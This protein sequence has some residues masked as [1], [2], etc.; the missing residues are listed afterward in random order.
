M[1][2][3]HSLYGALFLYFGSQHW[4]PGDTP[5]EITVGAMLTQ[6]VAWT[7]VEKAIIN[8][9]AADLLDL[10]KMSQSN[11]ENLKELIKPVGFYNQ[12]GTRLIDFA[13]YVCQKYGSIETM[14]DKPT[15]KVREELLGIKGIGPETADSILL[16]AGSHLTF[17]IDAYTKRLAR[18]LAIPQ[19][20]DYHALKNIFETNLPKDVQ[21][22][23]EYHALIVRLGK[24]FCKTKPD[25]ANCPVI[26]H[27]R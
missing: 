27:K 15:L 13:K 26:A 17:V 8:L 9:K 5:W 6:Q 18:C 4:W 16:Y 25:C 24:V 11:L 3:L 22:Y 1:T 23:N 19:A 2:K 21:V 20:E 7:N 14:L 10:E 12:K